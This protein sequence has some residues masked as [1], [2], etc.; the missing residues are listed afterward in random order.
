MRRRK[1][2]DPST[3]VAE[4]VPALPEKFDDFAQAM[5]APETAMPAPKVKPMGGM[6]ETTWSG[7]QMWRCPRCRS[8][9][10][11]EADSKVHVCK[12]PR[13]VDQADE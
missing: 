8:T 6:V 12:T 10:F 3:D 13:G 9:T 7:L 1:Q 5:T 2:I 4:E 11:R